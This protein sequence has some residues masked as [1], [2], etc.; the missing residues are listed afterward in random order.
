[1]YRSWPNVVWLLLPFL[2]QA[3]ALEEGLAAYHARYYVQAFMHLQPLAE[4]GVPAAQFTLGE[5]YRR[6][7]GFAKSVPEALPWLKQAAEAKHFPALKTS[8]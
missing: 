6:G 7:R 1:M 5:M 3:G 8:L 4:E 2:A